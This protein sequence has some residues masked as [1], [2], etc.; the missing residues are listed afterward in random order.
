[1]LLSAGTASVWPQHPTIRQHA[2]GI[3]RR[4]GG[5]I[6]SKVIL[7]VCVAL[8]SAQWMTVASL[9]PPTMALLEF[10][11]LRAADRWCEWSRAVGGCGM[12]AGVPTAAVLLLLLMMV[13][14]ASGMLRAV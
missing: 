9:P 1:M 6:R 10:G 3:S 12:R 5:C 7:I 8:P 4:P 13:P 14:L 11:M 2:S